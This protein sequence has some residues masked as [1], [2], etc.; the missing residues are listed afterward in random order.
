M[1]MANQLTRLATECLKD[2]MS[3]CRG[4]RVV[5]EYMQALVHALDH[6]R[7]CCKLLGVL[8]FNH[9]RNRIQLVTEGAAEAVVAAMSRFATDTKL[10]EVAC[11]VLTN[12]AHNSESNRKRILHAGGIDAILASMQAFPQ[13]PAVQKRCLWALLTL[14]GSGTWLRSLVQYETPPG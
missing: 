12:L 7:E 8:A 5:V 1:K 2:D 3:E 11:V 6:Q 13:H 10:L 4:I 9:D 14:A